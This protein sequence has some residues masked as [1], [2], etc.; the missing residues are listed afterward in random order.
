MPDQDLLR[1]SDIAPLLGVTTGRI[2][3]LIAAGI[4]PATRMGRSIRIPKAAWQRWLDDQRDRALETV[5]DACRRA[6]GQNR[7]SER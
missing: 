7:D 4:L 3:Q 2:Y 6:P 1:A 5:G